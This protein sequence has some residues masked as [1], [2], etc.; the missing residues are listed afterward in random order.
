[1]ISWTITWIVRG[2]PGPRRWVPPHQRVRRDRRVEFAERFAPQRVRSAPQSTALGI[3][4]SKASTAETLLQQPIFCLQVL[5]HLGLLAIDPASKQRQEEVQRR[6]GAKH[7]HQY[8]EIQ[9]IER[10]P[11]STDTSRSNCWILRG[12]QRQTSIRRHYDFFTTLIDRAIAGLAVPAPTIQGFRQ[13][14]M[15]RKSDPHALVPLPRTI[16]P[17]DCFQ[18]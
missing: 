8:S 14:G 7:R 12:P 6:N 1:M 9:L 18:N 13:I 5:D 17:S 11:C 2:R 16:R 4:E 10:V 15:G 3:C